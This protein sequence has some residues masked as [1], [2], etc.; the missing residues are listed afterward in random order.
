[1]VTYAHFGAYILVSHPSWAF[2]NRIDVVIIVHIA[3]DLDTFGGHMSTY[4]YISHQIDGPKGSNLCPADPF[5]VF[6]A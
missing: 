5:L 4:T 2:F 6:M 1:M 3:H